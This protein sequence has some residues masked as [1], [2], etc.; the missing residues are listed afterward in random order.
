MKLQAYIFLPS[1][2]T[3]PLCF[4][5]CNTTTTD[6]CCPSRPQSVRNPSSIS[7]LSFSRLR[8][9]M[10][11]SFFLNIYIYTYLLVELLT[12]PQKRRAGGEDFE[13]KF[14]R[15]QISSSFV[16][17]SVPG[18]IL[19]QIDVLFFHDF[20]QIGFSVFLRWFN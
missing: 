19:D 8:H 6:C 16:I 7:S 11:Q 14:R 2:P 15:M 9:F 1:C 17:H 20:F 18:R 3:H 4:A 13:L 10:V 5:R 12:I